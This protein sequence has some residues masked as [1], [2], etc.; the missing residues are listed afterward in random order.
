MAI[1][2]LKDLLEDKY[3]KW[4]E[5]HIPEKR[6]KNDSEGRRWFLK[7]IGYSEDLKQESLRKYTDRDS[8]NAEFVQRY[9]VEEVK[10]RKGI[11]ALKVEISALY[12]FSKCF[13]QR[14]RSRMLYYKDDLS[15]KKGRI[16]HSIGQAYGLFRA[17][18]KY[19][20][21]DNS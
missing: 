4:I 21:K 1:K 2:T 6:L 15:Q 20:D 3:P 17:F 13:V 19:L 7:S 8:L 11:S 5:E 10:K 12:A 18:K 16:N 9:K 14:Y